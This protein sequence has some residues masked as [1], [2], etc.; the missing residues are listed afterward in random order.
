MGLPPPT[1]PLYINHFPF[2]VVA[3]AARELKR[4]QEYAKLHNIPKA[5]GSYEELAQDPN[6][7]E[8]VLQAGKRTGVPGEGVTKGL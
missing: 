4:A 8:D 5:Y 2:Q 3:I 1:P 7:G 6:V